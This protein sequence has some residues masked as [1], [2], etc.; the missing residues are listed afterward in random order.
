[1]KLLTILIS[2]TLTLTVFDCGGQVTDSVKLP[3]SDVKRVMTRLERLTVDSIELQIRRADIV[4]LL[5]VNNSQLSTISNLRMQVTTF[6]AKEANYKGQISILEKDVK[7][8]KRKTKFAAI[9]GIALT[10]IV[11]G[12]FVFK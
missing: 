10:G 4:D 1:M 9:S 12:L 3:I 11:T 5:A 6:E 2:L 8:W 7:K